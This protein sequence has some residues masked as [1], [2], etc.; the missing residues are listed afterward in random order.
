IVLSNGVRP[1]READGAAVVEMEIDQRRGEERPSLRDTTGLGD[2]DEELV[3][4]MV[5]PE[6][7]SLLIEQLSFRLIVKPSRVEG[8]DDVRDDLVSVV[9][10]A[11]A[12]ILS[13]SL[14]FVPGPGLADD[15]V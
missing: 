13:H 5:P 6:L 4:G 11:T 12:K 7:G 10:A 1:A 14:R 2:G 15:G 8:E 3:A 9:I